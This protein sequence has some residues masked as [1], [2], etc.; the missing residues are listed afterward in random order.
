[1]NTTPTQALPKFSIALV[2]YKTLELTKICLELLKK[3][4][5]S[6]DLDPN[7]VDVWVVDNHSQDESV[8]YLRTLDWIHL[9]ERAPTEHEEGFVAHGRGLD[10]ILQQI[11]TDYLFLM[12]TDTFI[13]DASVFGWALKFCLADGKVA[14]VGCLEQLNRGYLRT[15]WRIS[16]RFCKHYSRRFKLFFGLNARQPKPYVEAYLKSFFALWNVKLMKQQGYVFLME[17]RIPGYALQ[18]KLKQD[19]YKLKVV[20][21][22]KLFKFLDHIEAGTVGLRALYSDMNRRVK[23]KKSILKKFES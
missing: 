9:I 2:N 20:S 19:G 8:E 16:S 5:D 11:K 6:A 18:D 15:A 12:H 21:P 17:N 10:L 23:R 4:L 14:A 7:S 22:M 13:Y 1:M 3:H